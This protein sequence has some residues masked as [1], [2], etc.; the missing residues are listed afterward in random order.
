MPSVGPLE[1]II[2]L[3]LATF[4]LGRLRLPEAGRSLGRR[5]RE[6]KDGISGE[7]SAKAGKAVAE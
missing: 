5:I 6:L 4:I 2:V 1:M 7:T 3:V